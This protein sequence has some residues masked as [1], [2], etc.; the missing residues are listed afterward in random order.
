METVLILLELT[1]AFDT[2]D[3]KILLNR[4]QTHFGI[5][6]TALAW[7]TSYLADRSQRVVIGNHYSQPRVLSYVV[8][9]GSVLG[10]LLFSIYLAPLEDIITAH[11][12]NVMFYADDSQLYISFGHGQQHDYIKRLQFC[13]EDVMN[14]MK[15]N[16]LI[17]NPSMTEVIHFNSRFLKSPSN[18]EFLMINNLK[19]KP[20]TEVRDLGVILDHHL[21]FKTQVNAICKSAYYSL[22]TIGRIRNY[23]SDQDCERLVHASI[24]SKMDYCNAILYGLPAT[25]INKL[26]RLQNTAVRIITRNKKKPTYQTSFKRPSF[27][28]CR[29]K[30]EFPTQYC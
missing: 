30:K 1:S 4:L 12:L 21:T 16:I 26:Q 19:I 9:Q 15:Q 28:G 25:E 13:L 6:D 23:L 2:I 8:P 24:S 27:T 22:T 3:H 10:S 18:I 11:S 14:W 17:C 29:R 20:T 5:S 7:F